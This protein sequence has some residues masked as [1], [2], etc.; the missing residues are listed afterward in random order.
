MP[1]SLPDYQ[2]VTNEAWA[3]AGEHTAFDHST[4]IKLFIRIIKFTHMCGKKMR[5]KLKVTNLGE[6]G[7]LDVWQPQPES[8]V[9]AD[10]DHVVVLKR[11]SLN[12]RT[13]AIL[14]VCLGSI[15]T[16][17]STGCC[18]SVSRSL[19]RLFTMVR[20]VRVG[21]SLTCPVSVSSTCWVG[22]FVTNWVGLFRTVNV[23]GDDKRHWR[24]LSIRRKCFLRR[25]CPF[26][27]GFRTRF[28]VGRCFRNSRY[29]V[30]SVDGIHPYR[31]SSRLDPLE[32]RP[33]DKRFPV[34]W[35]K[36]RLTD[37]CVL[38]RCG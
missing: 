8:R 13:R 23:V 10:V 6:K 21:L 28:G 31:G 19:V 34:G 14:I 37:I 12:M 26:S 38:G 35:L 2:R 16:V 22:L 9:V 36:R 4:T 7:V 17:T 1:S 33:S 30:E 29:D 5:L 18:H 27:S 15:I 20:I 25:N 3:T 24:F 32:R 11:G